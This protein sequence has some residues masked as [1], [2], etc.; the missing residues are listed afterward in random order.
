MAEKQIE[1]YDSHLANSI[2]GLFLPSWLGVAL[3]I[4]IAGVL[5]CIFN[6]RI[7]LDSLSNS[8][9]VPSSVLNGYLSGKLSIGE[10]F[11]TSLLQGRAATML[12]WAFIGSATYMVVWVA[13]NLIINISNDVKAGGF[14]SLQQD[15]IRKKA[16]WN[17]IISSKIFFACSVLA[18]LTY[19]VGLGRFFLPLLS[20]TF[21]LAIST[22]FQFPKTVLSIF[23]STVAMAV[24]LFILVILVRIVKRCGQW[25]IGNL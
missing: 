17:S 10:S 12:F 14:V 19:T 18:L 13:Q 1:S 22:S 20:K 3:Y 24:L 8:S 23:F 5:I 2:K 6:Y 4:L 15:A 7:L 21:G 16:Y 9:E 11:G 25:I